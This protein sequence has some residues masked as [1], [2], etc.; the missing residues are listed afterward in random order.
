[1]K[2][3]TNVYNLLGH[4]LIANQI[5]ERIQDKLVNGKFF[6]CKDTN[7]NIMSYTLKIKWEYTIITIILGLY[8]LLV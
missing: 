1:M 8:L 7:F 4:W 6:V 2:I 5:Y 3:D